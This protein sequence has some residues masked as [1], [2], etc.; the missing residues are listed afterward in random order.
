MTNNRK[1]SSTL[2]GLEFLEEKQLFRYYQIKKEFFKIAIEI[3]YSFIEVN[4]KKFL[5]RTLYDLPRKVDNILSLSCPLKRYSCSLILNHCHRIMCQ[6]NLFY[7]KISFS[8]QRDHS[9]R[10]MN[11]ILL[12]LYIDH[13]YNRKLFLIKNDSQI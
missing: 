12:P 4:Y 10:G 9:K 11:K 1:H 5:H 3:L 2:L 7:Y 13:N 6:I 8:L